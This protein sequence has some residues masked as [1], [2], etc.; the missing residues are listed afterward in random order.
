MPSHLRDSGD[1]HAQEGDRPLPEP[2]RSASRWLSRVPARVLSRVESRPLLVATGF[3]TMLAVLTY[4][5]LPPGF[6]LRF[7]N[8]AQ[9][10]PALLEVHRQMYEGQLPLWNP[11]MWSGAPLL[12][13][14]QSQA[15]YPFAWLTFALTRPDHVRAFDLAYAIHLVLGGTFCFLYLSTLGATLAGALLGAAIYTLNPQFMCIGTSFANWY[16]AFAWIPLILYAIERARIGSARWLGVAGVAFAMQLFAGHPQISAYTGL[17]LLL[18]APARAADPTTTHRVRTFFAG[19]VAVACGAALAA[20]LLLPARDMWLA[21]QRAVPPEG[22][23]GQISI[24][25]RGLLAV[26]LPGLRSLP[27]LGPPNAS[28]Y[29]GLVPCL[30]AL[31]AL[32]RPDPLR[33]LLGALGV[34][35]I[36]LS[37]G[38]YGPLAWALHNA[39]GLQ[40]FRGPFKYFFLIVLAVAALAALGLSDWQRGHRTRALGGFL[41]VGLD[42][43]LASALLLLTQPDEPTL[44]AT[45]RFE[46][47]LVVGVACVL[48]MMAALA[49]RRAR[50]TIPAL[51]LATTLAVM[52]IEASAYVKENPLFRIPVLF[53]SQRIPVILSLLRTPQP[54]LGKPGRVIWGGT[55]GLY[56]RIETADGYSGFINRQYGDALSWGQH[57]AWMLWSQ[58]QEVLAGPNRTI[59]VLNVRYLLLPLYHATTLRSVRGVSGLLRYRLG[60]NLDGIQLVGNTQALPRAYLATGAIPVPDHEH[61]VA[62]LRTGVIDPLRTPLVEE[63]IPTLTGKPARGRIRVV[64]QGPSMLRLRT[65]CARPALLVVSDAFDPGWHARVDGVAQPVLRTNA[66]TR[67]VVLPARKH[68]V[69]LYYWPQSLTRGALVSATTAALLLALLVPW[70]RRPRAAAPTSGEDTDAP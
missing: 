12:A 45:S 52:A 37:A 16:A 49:S 22:S 44:L 40:L 65:S 21:S 5:L 7:D 25:W 54:P 24:S 51:A 1:L 31:M 62:A 58:G 32:S 48:L 43:C 42:A 46:V 19:A 11:Y 34:L 35:G 39:P 69:L 10:L 28:T 70:R 3:F 47:Q 41:R 33:L 55:L 17:L 59:D 36:L 26:A 60:A 57:G 30:L 20:V 61:A 9:N 27:V 50:T 4:V 66:L 53:Q 64:A 68:D 15:F 18:Y 6:A 56:H 14:P 38:D 13:D 29:L 67:S 23:F 63:P 2:T 8:M